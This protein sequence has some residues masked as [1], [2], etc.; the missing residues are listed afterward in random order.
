M[1][2]IWVWRAEVFIVMGCL[3]ACS[4]WRHGFVASIEGSIATGRAFS[5]MQCS[6][7]DYLV[8]AL[9][10]LFALGREYAEV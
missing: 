7:L 10:A 6:H 9:K 8:E 5:D 4:L 2:W 1:L 3:L